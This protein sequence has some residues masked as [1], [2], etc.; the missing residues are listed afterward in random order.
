MDA[1]PVHAGRLEFD[2]DFL[3]LEGTDRDG[4]FDLWQVPL[5]AISGVRIGRMAH[6][7]IRGMPSL[8]VERGNDQPLLMADATGRGAMLD[9]ADELTLALPVTPRA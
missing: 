4:R 5:A 9:V 8:I 1:G 6:E 3:R 2:A 7:R